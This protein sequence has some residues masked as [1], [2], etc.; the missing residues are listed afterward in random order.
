MGKFFSYST[1]NDELAECCRA[2]SSAVIRIKLDVNGTRVT[3][4]HG[5]LHSILRLNKAL[6][7]FQMK[8]D[9]DWALDQSDWDNIRFFEGILSIADKAVKL[10][11]YEKQFLGSLSCVVKIDLLKRLRSD[12][13]SV[14]D[15]EAVTASPKMPRVD[16]D[17]ADM[18]PVGEECL[19]RARLEAERR[20]CENSGEELTSGEYCSSDR[21]LGATL[22]DLRTVNANH[23]S[24]AKRGEALAVLKDEY[25]IFGTRAFEYR[26][27]KKKKAV[28]VSVVETEN[29][30]KPGQ[31]RSD[32]APENTAEHSIS[33]SSSLSGDDFGQDSWDLP[34]HP[35]IEEIP[36]EIPDFGEEFD[37][38]WP[39]WVRF[40]RAVDWKSEF[41]GE[42][43]PNV[44][45]VR[46]LEHL[47][48]LN[49]GKI[50]KS[51]EGDKRFG[52]LP[53]MARASRCNIG[54]LGAQSF[55]E[56][57]IS[58]GNIVMTDGNTLLC[59]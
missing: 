26:A 33:S 31:P 9:V 39:E 24:T 58:A 7:L 51:I 40:A 59:N 49:I 36:D 11:Q 45:K 53:V 28:E 15:A 3:A 18:S 48:P 25:G 6:K 35:E 12:S 32:N 34:L 42:I 20:Y 55:C 17:V 21:E 13:I 14:V 5:L 30:S 16:V 10:A 27:Q 44:K 56:R 47:L 52:H 57:I 1:K 37:R 19:R 43:D 4:K 29:N 8:N 23:L 22:L 2:V 46:V 41:P 54:A 38:V 50:Y